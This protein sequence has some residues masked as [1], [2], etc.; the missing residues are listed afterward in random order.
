MTKRRRQ[1]LRGISP[2]VDWPAKPKKRTSPSRVT[3]PSCAHEFDLDPYVPGIRSSADACRKVREATRKAP[4]EAFWALFLNN[5]NQVVARKEL[6]RGTVNMCITHP[7]DVFREAVAHNA[8]AVIVAHNHPSGDPSPS[9]EDVHLTEQLV[10]AGKIVGIPLLDHV[11][12]SETGCSSLRE[13]GKG[14]F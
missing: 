1:G 4:Q 2:F 3:C 14:G 11:V 10:Q 7:R 12:V 6:C 8:A 13:A 9:M 5:R